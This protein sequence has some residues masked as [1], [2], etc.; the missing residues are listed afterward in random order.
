MLGLQQ[1]SVDTWLAFCS[2]SYVCEEAA[3]H[4]W[5]RRGQDLGQALVRIGQALEETGGLSQLDLSKVISVT[6]QSRKGPQTGSPSISEGRD[7]AE[8]RNE[9]HRPSQ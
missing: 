3:S 8:C 2:P 1:K 6:Q 5:P 7:L 4:A 9:L